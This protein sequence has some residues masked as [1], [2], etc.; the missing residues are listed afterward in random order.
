MVR[1]RLCRESPLTGWKGMTLP[2]APG[3]GLFIPGACHTASAGFGAE[4]QGAPAV[5][6]VSR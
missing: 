4:P 1:S 2:A 3:M 5:T 6:R